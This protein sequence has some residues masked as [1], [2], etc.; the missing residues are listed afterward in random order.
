MLH[1]VTPVSTRLSTVPAAPRHG[2]IRFPIERS[3]QIVDIADDSS[4][5]RRKSAVTAAM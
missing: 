5:I 1:H 3:R 4:L 2:K